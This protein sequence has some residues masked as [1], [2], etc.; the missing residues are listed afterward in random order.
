MQKE[1]QSMLALIVSG[2]VCNHEMAWGIAKGLQIEKEL[3]EAILPSS[4]MVF[5]E[6]NADIA[7]FSICNHPVTQREY[8]S[9]MGKNP[10]HFQRSAQWLDNPVEMVN[11]HDCIAF[12]ERLSELTGKNYCLPTEEE[13]E[14]AARGG[15]YTQ[16]FQYAGSN[17]VEDVA[18]YRIKSTKRV[19]MKQANELGLYDMSGN[20][21]EWCNTNISSYRVL[22]GGSWFAYSAFNFRS[23]YRSYDYPTDASIT[24][25][26]RLVIR[27]SVL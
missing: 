14:Y 13:W 6:G 3:C 11:F 22:R 9:I 27:P 5:V 17:Q 24:D 10:S 8:L 26:F 21:C 7:S 4:E 19:K 16:G 15:K 2:Q 23:A 18:W 20:V 1:I 25:G 12:C